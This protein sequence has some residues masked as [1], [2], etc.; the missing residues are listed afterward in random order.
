MSLSDEQWQFLQDV[1]KL[2]QFAEENGLKL[3]AGE[4]YRTEYQHKHNLKIG[5]SNV[6]RSL[7]QDRLAIDI[8][9]FV[10]GQPQWNMCDEW[11][12]LGEYWESLSFLNVWGGR[13]QEPFDP[14]HF[15]RNK[16]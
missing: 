1:A 14:Y 7:H 3:T 4:L 2:I 15:Q 10:D 6:S 12:M 11:V 5:L 13:W 16:A 9:L 8:N